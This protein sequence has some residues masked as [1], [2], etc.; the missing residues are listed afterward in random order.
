MK[1]KWIVW[2]LTCLSFLCLL[3]SLSGCDFIEGTTSSSSGSQTEENSSTDSVDEQEHEL[4]YV[5][6]KAAFCTEEGNIAHY[7]CPLCNKAFRDIDEKEEIASID[8]PALGHNEVNHTAQA[9]S[10]TKIGWNAYVT[11]TRCE[12]TTYEEIPALG[13]DEVNHTAQAATCTD[14]GWNAYVTCTRCEYTTYEEIP[15]LGH[16]EVNHNAQAATCTEIGWNAYVTCTRCE[17]TTYEEIPATGHT[18]SVDEEVTATCTSTGLTA[19]SH[20]SVCKEVL[21]AQQ[22]IPKAEHTYDGE[23]ICTVCSYQHAHTYADKLTSDDSGHWYTPT[24]GH[25][26]VAEKQKHTFN[27]EYVCEDCGYIDRSHTAVELSADGLIALGLKDKTVTHLVIPDGVTEIADYAFESCKFESVVIPDSVV[28]I[29]KRAFYS[30]VNLQEVTLGKGVK[31]IKED[32]FWITTS[33]VH[34]VQKV[35]YTGTLTEW[36][37]IEFV[38]STSHP[39]AASNLYDTYRGGDLYIDNVLLTDLVLPQ[40]ITEVTPYM[41][42][43][44][45]S[46][47][48]V[49]FS[50]NVERI[51]AGA[52]GTKYFTDI[53]IEEGNPYYDVVG[54]CLIERATKTLVLGCGNS[55]IPTDGSVVRIGMGAFSSCQ[56]LTEITIPQTVTTIESGAFGSSHF[57]KE[58]T[59]PNSVVSIGESAF[60]GCYSL[61]SIVIPDG[62]EEIGERT[63]ENCVSLQSI[64]ISGNIEVIGGRAFLDCVNLQTLTIKNGVKEIENHA[65]SGCESLTAVFLP[66]SVERLGDYAFSFCASLTE[67]VVPENVTYV[68]T[69]AFAY[70]PNLKTVYW[71]AIECK[72]FSPYTGSS[73]NAGFAQCLSLEEFIFGEKVSYIP[74]NLLFG[75]GNKITNIRIPDSVTQVEDQAFD[76]CTNLEYQEFENGLY[77]GNENNPYIILVKAKDTGITACTVHDDAKIIGARAFDGCTLLEEMIIPDGVLSIHN[78]AFLNCTSLKTLSIPESVCT[79]GQYSVFTNVN[80]LQTLTIPVQFLSSSS[81]ETSNVRTLTITGE[82]ELSWNIFLNNKSLISVS[83]GAGVTAIHSGAFNGCDNLTEVY[84]ADVAAWCAIEFASEDSNPLRYAEKVYVNNQLTTNLV[85]PEGVTEIKNYAFY[86]ARFEGYSLPNT[87]ETIG[88]SAFRDC[89][90]L[91]EIVIPDSVALIKISAFRGC[92]SL[93]KITMGKGVKTVQE[94]AFECC[95]ALNEVHVVDLAAWCEIDFVWSNAPYYIESNPLYYAHNLY[96]NGEL[97]LNLVIPEGVTAVKYGAF[98]GCE[99]IVSVTLPSTLERIE[100]YAFSGCKRLKEVY[101]FSQ[102]PIV[103]DTSGVFGFVGYYADS[104]HTEKDETS[105]VYVTEDGYVFHTNSRGEVRLIGYTGKDTQLVL[106]DTCNGAPYIIFERAFENNTSITSVHIGDGATN[107]QWYAFSGCTVLKEVFIGKGVTDVSDLAFEN[108]NALTNILVSNENET[109]QSID[110][111]LYTKDGKTLLLYIE[112]NGETEYTVPD[113]VTTIESGAFAGC[114]S[115]ERVVLPGSVTY[116]GVGAFSGCSA[117]VSVNIPA[118]V[119]MIQHRLF[120]G[121]SSL[122]SLV[123]PDGVITIGSYAFAGCNALTSLILPNSVVSIENGAFSDCGLTSIVIPEGV[124]RIEDQSFIGCGSLTKIIIPNSVTY[125]SSNAFNGCSSLTSVIIPDSVTYMGAAFLDCSNLT[126]IIL[127]NSITRIESYTFLN[128]SNLTD[129]IIPDGVTSIGSNAFTGCD[130]IIEIIDGVYYVGTWV[131]GCD[132]TVTSVVLR[133]GTKGIADYAFWNRSSL[134]SITIP[135]RVNLIG[136]SAFV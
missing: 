86:G 107:I 71:N 89:T 54:E 32:A 135:G 108:C 61:Q 82:G 102:L 111:T 55:V 88:E 39:F 83:I 115:L 118:G 62:V 124:T 119:T 31:L 11:F 50:K 114:E 28:T 132:E 3:F 22:E 30:Y 5:E 80:G 27:S 51:S 18:E 77:L 40:E 75:S 64:V 120:E 98:Y 70:C 101:N 126:S 7:Y 97:A 67:I 94:W 25:S 1:K 106:P 84:I 112:K 129:I 6:E 2:L 43:N 12:Y 47:K 99:W 91:K 60:S 92:S 79:M 4:V 122:T 123:L 69:A 65:F 8:I 131:I 45:K 109:Y 38:T 52:F 58:I 78:Y 36:C 81:L 133:E 41:F 33:M 42:Y 113:G 15:A 57:L 29:G 46:L 110:G 90:A 24:C 23:Y 76:W 121:C 116:I 85:V 134:T 37:D 130:K 35:Y 66:N 16:N 73:L 96:L 87:I 125:V 17:Y 74:S 19:G 104:V 127:P 59:I 13:H 10:C 48:S 20:C 44:C 72:T 103:A 34:S 136:E 117:L 9:A 21:V 53:N 93:A 56:A 26:D 95:S 63:F 105:N 49:T 14:I 100:D 128:C 68:G